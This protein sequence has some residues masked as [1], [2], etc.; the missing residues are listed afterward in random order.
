M[1]FY[2][3]FG[4]DMSPDANLRAAKVRKALRSVHIN[5]RP[6]LEL[7]SKLDYLIKLSELDSDDIRPGLTV[8]GPEGAGKSYPLARFAEMTNRRAGCEKVVYFSF[9][10]ARGTGA[11]L[12]RLLTEIGADRWKPRPGERQ[13]QLENM[14]AD[15]I[16]ANK[17]LVLI[18]DEI[19]NANFV[20]AENTAMANWIKTAQSDRLLSIVLSGTEDSRLLLTRR[21]VRRRLAEDCQIPLLTQSAQDIIFLNQALTHY[22]G[23]MLALGIV[24]Q[25]SHLAD[26]ETLSKIIAATGG[27]LGYIIDLLKKAAVNAT[28]R[29]ASMIAEIDLALGV[30]D[31]LIA[32]KLIKT[33]PFSYDR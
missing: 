12:N 8:F 11:F 15:V 27:G 25:R 19:A 17:T 4:R 18:I 30:E 29:G 22:E 10:T 23:Q 20:N 26:P 7:A 16:R 5:Y 3:H 33:N 9:K 6:Q 14:L 28:R 13:A 24:Q 21:D 1:K 2:D 31:W 32:Q